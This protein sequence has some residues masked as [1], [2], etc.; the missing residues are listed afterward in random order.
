M[1][2]GAEQTVTQPQRADDFGARL[3]PEC[4]TNST[5]YDD[6]DWQ[7]LLPHGKKSLALTDKDGLRAA[8]VY[9]PDDPTFVGYRYE[10]ESACMAA[11]NAQLGLSCTVFTYDGI[12]ADRCGGVGNAHLLPLCPA[13]GC[14]AQPFSHSYEP[15]I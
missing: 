3:Y 6:G 14:S 1:P 11:C 13:Y 7:H 5:T 15:V 8:G 9:V 10:P 2:N 12:S 4:I